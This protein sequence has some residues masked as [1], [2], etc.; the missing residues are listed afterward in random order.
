MRWLYV[1]IK[2]LEKLN[3]RCIRLFGKK[4]YDIGYYDTFSD[5]QY[6][7][8]QEFVPIYKGL[9]IDAELVNNIGDKL[10][11]ERNMVIM[12]FDKKRTLKE[13]REKPIV[14]KKGDAFLDSNELAIR[15]WGDE[16]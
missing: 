4:V 15:R 10:G 16:A 5:G 13:R 9:F 2:W 7:Y 3:G 6:D 12:Q 14:W 1:L 8:W 11:E